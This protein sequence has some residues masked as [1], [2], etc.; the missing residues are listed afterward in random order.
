M[1]T[2]YDLKNKRVGKLIVKDL[3][4]IEKRPTKTHGN[5]WYCDCDCGTKN[6]MVPTS[7]L[8]GNGNY[9]QKSCGCDRKLK[10]FISTTDKRIVSEDF[11]SQ[12][13]DLEKYLFIHK[14]LIHTNKKNIS[15]YTKEEYEEL[16]SYFYFQKE[17]NALYNF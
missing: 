5:Y 3:V 7:Y 2:K 15:Q 14:A 1:A 8:T 11:V 12:F 4:P 9:T 6:I 17:F 13:H 10:A 16:I